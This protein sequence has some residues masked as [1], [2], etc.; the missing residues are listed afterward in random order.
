MVG[1]EDA[2]VT[3]QGLR[4]AGDVHHPPGGAGCQG[5]EELPAGAG[6]GRVHEHHIPALPLLGGLGQELPGVAPGEPGVFHGVFLGVL[7]GVLHRVGVQL[8]PQHLSGAV[9]GRHQ[10]DGADAAVGVQHLLL[11][12]ELR[13]LHGLAVE[14]L[15]LHG[16]DLVEG[17]GRDAEP[18]AAQLVH[19]V[20]RA[21]EDLLP[22]PQHQGGAL[23]VDVLQNGGNLRVELPQLCHK[24]LFGG[25]HRGARHQH[26]HHLAR[27]EPPL[28]Q[29][30][31]QE[32]PAGV[33]VV[34]LE[35]E[36]L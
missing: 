30:M 1:L 15:C 11:A 17:L 32:A 29:H 2:Q 13:E 12:G 26:H 36:I 22:L 19:N 23:V 25:E 18:A 33:L 28:Y 4:V 16:V 21:V 6:P 24:V 35:L 27:G 31:A 7:D 20:P 8:H 10:A 14:H 34:G 5:R 9:L 3:G